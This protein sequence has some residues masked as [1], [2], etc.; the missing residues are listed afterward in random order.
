MDRLARARDRV[1][2]GDD[3]AALRDLWWLR[4]HRR[5]N[6]D[7]MAPVLVLALELGERTTG[8]PCDEATQIANDARRAL[9]PPDPEPP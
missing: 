1:E 8:G 6:K 7:T 3:R 5:Y 9:N 4:N 2:C